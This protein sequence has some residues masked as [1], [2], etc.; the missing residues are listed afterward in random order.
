M[1]WISMLCL[2]A[3]S[4]KIDKMEM[5]VRYGSFLVEFGTELRIG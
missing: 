4:I 5:G 2:A 1:S 3:K